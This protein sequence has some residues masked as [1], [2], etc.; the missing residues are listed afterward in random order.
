MATKKSFKL[1]LSE[2]KLLDDLHQSFPLNLVPDMAKPYAELIRIHKPAGIMAFYFPFLYG[3]FL[4]GALGYDID[5]LEMVITNAELL[6][7]SFLM[8]GALCTWNDIAD[9]DFDRQ[10]ARTRTRPLA[11]GAISTGNALLWTVLQASMVLATFGLFSRNVFVCAAPFLI[12]HI[13]YPF[14]K[15]WTHH[16]QLIL[17][18][19]FSMGV[20]VSFPALGQSIPENITGVACLSAAVVLWTLLY[21]TIY[22]AQDVEDDR[23]AGVGSTMVYWGDSARTFLRTLGVLQLLSLVAISLVINKSSK[24]SASGMVYSAMTCGST[25]IGLF[26]M[27]EGVNL[28]EPASCGWWFNRGNI[29]VGYGISSGLIGEYLANRFSQAGYIPRYMVQ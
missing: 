24:L 4:V 6:L 22:A 14:T 21:D 5:I 25:A 7:L 23:K 19:A 27:I 28:Q 2:Q 12:F 26:N 3:T 20:S 15:R 18:F 9:Q 11:R 29:L 10:I 13:I 1:S 16:P 8:R 17:G